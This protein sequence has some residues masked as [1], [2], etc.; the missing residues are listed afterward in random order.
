[1]KTALLAALLT[2]LT[3]GGLTAEGRKDDKGDGRKALEGTW[4]IVSA[5]RDGKKVEGNVA[6]ATVV[7]DGD[8]YKILAGDKAVEEG[9]FTADASKTP[10]RID[11]T[12]TTG[13]D[14]GKK[15]HGVYELEG[16]TLRAVVGPTDK[17][18]PT[19]LADPAAGT[20]GFTLKRAK[21]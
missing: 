13:E 19:K 17:D 11:V 6:A 20:R 3:A 16:D 15:W 14:K 2:G 5:E 4:T 12:V 10:N 21:R 9:T 8:K 18:R 1:M 7:F